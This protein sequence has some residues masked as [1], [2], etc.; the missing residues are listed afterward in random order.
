MVIISIVD[1]AYLDMYVYIYTVLRAV[2]PSI[3]SC[4]LSGPMIA[5][6][7]CN[8]T[9][10]SVLLFVSIFLLQK[11]I[12]KKV[13]QQAEIYSVTYQGKTVTESLESQ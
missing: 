11:Q 4:L 6:M 7:V 9:G 3:G 10:T 1:I 5:K 8:S 12:G 2:V 13:I